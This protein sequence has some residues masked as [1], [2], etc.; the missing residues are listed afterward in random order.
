MAAGDERA[1]AAVAAVRRKESPRMGAARARAAVAALCRGNH[2]QRQM[3]GGGGQ[4][5]VVRAVQDACEDA[6]LRIEELA[7]VVAANGLPVVGI[8]SSID[9]DIPF[10]DMALGVDTALNNIIYAVDCI[11][12]TA[13]S[14]DRAFIVEVMG[15]GSG[16]FSLNS[17]CT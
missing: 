3:R 8:P 17:L 7:E 1:R 4:H 2:L 11:K 9:N 6:F 14:H 12:D 15:R 16:R 10:T 13:S 5:Q